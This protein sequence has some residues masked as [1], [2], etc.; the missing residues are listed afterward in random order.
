[1][2]IQKLP[3]SA[4]TPGT[5]TVTQLESSVAT[6]VQTGGG[7][8][9]TAIT[10]TN[11]SYTNLDD[12][13]VNVSGGYIKITGTGFVTG[14]S[15]I[16]GS[17]VA[18][19]VSFISSTEVR[20]QVPAQ[21]AGTYT[22]YLVNP[23]GGVGIRVNGLNYSSTPTWS[24]TSPL[25]GS[26]KDSAISIQLVATSNS[27]V[28][29]SLQAG[30]SLP[31]GLTLSSGGLLSGTVTSISVETTYNFTIVATDGENQD[32]PQA[33][34]ITIVVRDPYYKYV[35]LHLP[36]TGANLA[37]NNTFLDSSSN[38]FAI[39][40]NGNTTQGTFSPFSQTGWSNYFDGSGDCLTIAKS[41]SL[42]PSGDF[43]IECWVYQSSLLGAQV[44]GS[45]EAGT[46]ANWI[47]S[48]GSDG[49]VYMYI[50]TKDIF[51]D[52]SSSQATLAG[53]WNH[54][55][56]SRT[57]TTLYIGCNGQLTTHLNIN[58]SLDYGANLPITIGADQ[59]GDESNYTGYISDIR[60]INGTGLYSGST[61]TV[62]TAPLTA[63]AGTSLLTCQ[64]NRFR[65]ASTNNF[66]IT[67]NGNTSV[68][69]FG[70]FDPTTSWSAATY[71]GSGYFDGT[72][73]YLT[74]P[75]NTA[76]DLGSG[77]F[78]LEAWV[79]R[80]A[81]GS[82]NIFHGSSA[83]LILYIDSSNKAVVRLFGV[84][85][86]LTS[87]D[88]IA[89]NTWTH[90]AVARS[91]TTLSMWL[92]GSRSSGGTVSN[93]SNFGQTG[94]IIG[95]ND[96]STS[97]YS[98]YMSSL[99]LVK[100]TAVYDPTQSSITVPTSPLTAVSGTSLLLNF[101]NAGIRD[102]AAK[103]V[104]ET[105]GD[106]KISTAQSKWSGSSMAFDGTGDYLVSRYPIADMS[107]FGAG[108]FTIEMWIRFTNAAPTPER[109]FLDF[110]PGTLN[111][112]APMFYVL[113]NTIRYY[114]N[115]A[116]RITSGTISSGQWYYLAVTRSGTS[117]RMFIDGT[118][119][120][121]TYT[122]S[123]S[124]ISGAS[125]PVIG[126]ARDGTQGIDGYIQDLR[127]TRGYAR[128]TANFAAPTGAFP[129]L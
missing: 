19:S 126:A 40:R 11:N 125:Y 3:G 90:V 84:A 66:A 61:Y 79:Y 74:V 108:N 34:Q 92:N 103:N 70:P 15:V 45:H 71:G 25:P 109:I 64:S 91:G 5:I 43:T 42:V 121:S 59:N 106:A 1:M 55:V 80:T 117:T 16:I 110:R 27:A 81:S 63:V 46:S 30:S 96:I 95:T 102:A 62:P 60:I 56:A 57:G 58:T 17:L 39:T 113:S 12:T 48:V 37:Q 93:S 26:I 115:G 112:I 72:G 4:I 47:F 33:F 29:F 54:I 52:F 31:P 120:G 76:F 6:T 123:N 13:A 101:T 88:A 10:V 94:V 124:Y 38:N 49:R 35:T 97:L 44:I 2:T 14:C 86:L 69:A 87:A 78:T 118:Q 50:P 89:I 65:D 99:R 85:D 23:D 24:T 36:G 73:D 129:T 100:G 75:S 20:A 51:N 127:I 114:V 111:Q 98:G 9:I 53:Q 21:S 7:P 128:Y 119:S 105:V 77:A 104:L 67:V 18:T 28:T 8:K 82:V 83:G 32:T 116:D 41:S 107:A 122:D 68:Q 22:V